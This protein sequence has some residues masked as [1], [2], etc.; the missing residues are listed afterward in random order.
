MLYNISFLLHNSLKFSIFV[1]ELIKQMFNPKRC[2][3]DIISK[4][5]ESYSRTLK[6]IT[7]CPTISCN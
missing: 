5:R 6:K 7:C 4:R 2:T 3:Y 1:Y